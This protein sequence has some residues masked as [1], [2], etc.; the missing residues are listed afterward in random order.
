MRNLRRIALALA[1]SLTAHAVLGVAVA[2]LWVWRGLA[3]LSVPVAI[4]LSTVRADE[5]RELPLGIE[6]PALP[7]PAASAPEPDDVVLPPPAELPAGSAG[8]SP[9]VPVLASTPPQV[10]APPKPARKTPISKRSPA[11]PVPAAALATSSARGAVAAGRTAPHVPAVNSV[12]AYAPA[13]SR[14]VALVRLDRLRGTAYAGA[15]DNLLRLLPDRRDLLEGTD[16]DLY[17]DVDALLVATPNPRDAFVTLLVVRHRLS[18]AELRGALEKGARATGRRLVWH[19][20][21]GRPFAER[22]PSGVSRGVVAGNAATATVRRRDERLIVLPAPK[23]AVVTPPSYRKLI[24]ESPRGR[25]RGA[26]SAVAPA[27]GES[28]GWASLIDRIDAED[29]ILPADA[30]AMLSA[31]GIFPSSSGD[32]GIVVLGVRL[33]S[34]A[35]LTAVI[36]IEPHPFANLDLSFDTAEAAQRWADAWPRLRQQLL[37]NPLVVLTG[38][39]HLLSGISVTEDGASARVHVETTMDETIRILTFLTTE[40]P[41]LRR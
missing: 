24:L 37:G 9:L 6:P 38:F 13:G 33:P 15:V 30:V 3:V 14:V 21:R 4:D 35:S 26:A 1:V 40:L 7:S 28:D 10:P 31:S 32:G 2:G 12:R 11:P 41:L 23:L 36:G 27:P 18:D 8:A 5:L 25:A 20:E 29:S 22:L 16:L 17:R 34:P 39:S 19:T